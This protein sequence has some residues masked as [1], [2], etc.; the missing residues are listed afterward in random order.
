MSVKVTRIIW[1]TRNLSPATKMVALCIAD[2]ANNESL[3]AY[4]SYDT[5]MEECELSRMTVARAIKRIAKLGLVEVAKGGHGRRET[6][7]YNFAG[8]VSQ[9]PKSGKIGPFDPADLAPLEGE[10]CADFGVRPCYSETALRS[11]I[12]SNIDDDFGVTSE[13]FRSNI[14]DI[15][16]NEP[17]DNR[18]IEPGEPAKTPAPRR[19]FC[20]DNSAPT[21]PQKTAPVIRDNQ[22]PQR[23]APRPLPAAAIATPP[24]PSATLPTHRQGLH[25]K[26]APRP[27]PSPPVP[28]PLAQSQPVQSSPA[29]PDERYAPFGSVERDG[30]FESPMYRAVLSACDQGPES[31]YKMRC[32]IA[33][34]AVALEDGGFNAADVELAR[35]RWYLPRAP[36]PS[37]LQDSIRGL[38]AEKATEHAQKKQETEEFNA[39]QQ[40]TRERSRVRNEQR[41]AER[42][43][44]QRNPG[45][46]TPTPTPSAQPHSRR[47]AAGRIPG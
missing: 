26:P 29:L 38:L 19:A 21:R 9:F 33:M 6:S 7:R 30:R 44:T 18:K 17:L 14:D 15:P 16:S 32:Q 1:K 28:R 47:D 46:P 39:K 10:D 27:A 35:S 36:V 25:Q 3:V 4:P 20:E 34:A 8:L 2:H 31:S 41:A 40:Q 43:A 5:I 12:R 13:T 24:S 23:V 45:R 11:N 42:A 37:Q 22:T